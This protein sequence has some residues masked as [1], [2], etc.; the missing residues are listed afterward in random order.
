MESPVLVRPAIFQA[1]SALEA[2]LSAQRECLR[3]HAEWIARLREAQPEARRNVMRW[4]KVDRRAPAPF[5]ALQHSAAAAQAER[6]AQKVMDH[7]EQ[8][9]VL[10]AIIRTNSVLA[11][12]AGTIIRGGT[13]APPIKV[14]PPRALT[15]PAAD[16]SRE[17]PGDGR[18][19]PAEVRADA[20]PATVPS[21]PPDLPAAVIEQ[22]LAAERATSAPSSGQLRML[23]AKLVH[24]A[25]RAGQPAFGGQVGA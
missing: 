3:I 16:V 1:Q 18:R 22:A 23:L 21:V 11:A 17:G 19:D 20:C 15:Q 12:Q 24:R 8:R 2:R 6:R 10:A 4:P 13:I 5:Q 9:A 14:T 25:L 7:K